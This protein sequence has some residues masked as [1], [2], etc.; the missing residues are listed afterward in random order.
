MISFF[1]QARV[2]STR[3]PNKILLPFYQGKCI[4]ELLI[5]KLLMVKG[6]NIV[7]ATSIDP[8]NHAIDEVASKYGIF[9]FHGSENDVLQR[10]V[11]AAEATGTEKL[12]RICS[13]NPF[14][15]LN[16]I[17]EL[18]LKASVSEKDYISFNIGGKPSIKT[19]YG[20][21]T[22]FVT[23]KAL[24]RVISLTNDPL[25]HEH[26]TNYIYSHPETFNIEWIKGP[27]IIE[28]HPS[29]RLTIDTREDF[30]TIK[31]IYSDLCKNNPFPTIEDVVH[32]LDKHAEY[33]TTM[34]EQID[35]NN[36]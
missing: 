20:F 1:I 5:E 13:D 7:I 12:I 28:T 18:V 6:T 24:Q 27:K 4:L 10:F 14:L 21:W 19:H 17:N 2:G 22:E 23:K 16:S 8:K 31:L 11:D 3:L 15:E 32:Y 26:V 29:I 36:K 33:Y 9:C 25:Y 30:E 34:Q 35:K